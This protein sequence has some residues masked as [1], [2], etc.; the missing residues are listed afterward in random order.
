MSFPIEWQAVPINDLTR[1]GPQFDGGYCVS[2][3]TVRSS[4]RLL[5]FG[6]NDDWRFE[7]HFLSINSVPLSCFDHTVNYKFWILHLVKSAL[8]LRFT[9][10]IH[11]FRYRN[12]FNNSERRHVQSM[13]GY[14]IDGGVSLDRLMRDVTEQNIF[15][16][17]DIEGSEYRVL[18]QIIESKKRF[19]GLVIEFHDVDLHRERLKAFVAALDT[20]A[21]VW[22]HA[23][24]YGGRSA[25]GD[26]IVIEMSF[27]RKDL[28]PAG[29]VASLT[30]NQRHPNNPSQAEIDLIFA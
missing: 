5:S 6:L 11:Y 30:G 29:N 27:A 16:K 28:L 14:D 25:D 12:F 7:Q 18:D 17:M 1:I 3:S 26:P 4:D 8:N 21:I 24:N 23:N 20:H 13:I 9:K 22:I 2:S 15:L 19:S 10:L